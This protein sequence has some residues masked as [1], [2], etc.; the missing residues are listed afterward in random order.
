MNIDIY[1]EAFN[2]VLQRGFSFEQIDYFAIP[3]AIAL[4][5][6]A[7]ILLSLDEMKNKLIFRQTKLRNTDENKEVL[8]KEVK[9]L[10][11]KIKTRKEK[12]NKRTLLV[13]FF[14]FIIWFI[15]A[16]VHFSKAELTDSTKKELLEIEKNTHLLQV[17]YQKKLKNIFN[18]IKKDG[19][20]TY[21]EVKFLTSEYENIQENEKN[22]KAAKTKKQE[23]KKL[24]E[25]FDS[26]LK[27]E[28]NE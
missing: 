1:K 16:T 10:T 7:L 19:K 3:I 8:E 14:T 13:L 23:E 18:E 11:N 26:F 20:I 5:Y 28:K 4:I 17:K 6:Y 22:E 21:L 12:V 25:K 27:G 15:G 9:E 24:N 2:I